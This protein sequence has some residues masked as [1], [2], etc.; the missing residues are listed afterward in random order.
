MFSQMSRSKRTD[1]LVPLGTTVLAT[2]FAYLC[3]AVVDVDL[4]VLLLLFGVVPCLLHSLFLFAF[5]GRGWIRFEIALLLVVASTGAWLVSTNFHEARI[6]ARWS[7]YSSAY[8]ERTIA[9]ANDSRGYLQHTEWDGWGFPGAGN[10]VEYLVFDPGNSLAASANTAD[11]GKMDGIP[12]PIA[13]TTL[14]ENQWY[15]VLLYTGTDWDHCS[16]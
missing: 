12:C 8:Q 2:V 10:T 13:E 7:I 5:T 14:V 6:I 11:V 4:G 9:A 16:A 15:V 1:W 3:I